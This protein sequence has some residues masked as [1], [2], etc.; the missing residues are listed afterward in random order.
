M[1]RTDSS[2]SSERSG[3]VLLEKPPQ[4][5]HSVK[6][7]QP[8]RFPA[9]PLP[10]K[11]FPFEVKPAVMPHAVSRASTQTSCEQPDD[12]TL[13]RRI[14]RRDETALA[15]LH[16]RYSPTLYGLSLKM[17]HNP[18]EAEE[19]LQDVFVKLWK[20]AGGY[21]PA[22]ASF[23]TWLVMITRRLC[24]DR[25]RARNR[26]PRLDQAE[27]FDETRAVLPEEE[28]V[29]RLA[30]QAELAEHIR[31]HL[32]DLPAGQGE[33]IRLA[34]FN[35]MTHAE[36]AQALDQ[37]LGTVKARIRR[38]MLRLRTQLKEIYA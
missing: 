28:S 10:G 15:E 3:A 20:N 26:R 2:L 35:G 32:D 5:D 12:F 34:F 19:V 30:G 22:R 23:F 7:A 21:D 9:G 6:Q 25:I 29:T 33:C 38:G 11:R 17:L 1:P 18:A 27:D 36:I 8:G 37:P 24:I 14:S 31:Q 13:V 4:I 16:R